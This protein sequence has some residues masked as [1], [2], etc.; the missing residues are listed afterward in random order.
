MSFVS[1]LTD[2]EAAIFFENGECVFMYFEDQEDM[3]SNEDLLKWYTK[4]DNYYPSAHIKG[5]NVHPSRA[6]IIKLLF[7]GKMVNG[8]YLYTDS[9][10]KAWLSY[11]K[12]KLKESIYATRSY[13]FTKTGIVAHLGNKNVFNALLKMRDKFDEL[14]LDNEELKAK[15]EHAL[16]YGDILNAI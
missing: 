4:S 10:M 8:K 2:Y 3:P 9:T 7:V 13:L 5:R 14:K 12:L 1:R 16:A 15:L 6:N 11:T